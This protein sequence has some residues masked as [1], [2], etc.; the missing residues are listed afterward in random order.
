M[1]ILGMVILKWNLQE[2]NVRVWTEFISFMVGY[3]LGSCEHINVYCLVL[4]VYNF[5]LYSMLNVNVS[6]VH[7]AV[8]IIMIVIEI[9]F[10][11]NKAR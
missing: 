9:S 7:H 2:R 11:F 3:Y 8:H 10:L 6:I 4:C 5:R 1:G